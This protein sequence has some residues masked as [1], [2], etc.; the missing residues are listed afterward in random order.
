MPK[1]LVGLNI[2]YKGD[3][4]PTHKDFRQ[5]IEI[6]KDADKYYDQG[7]YFFAIPEFFARR[8]PKRMHCFPYMGA[9]AT[10]TQNVKFGPNVLEVPLF[11]PKHTADV[12]STLDIMSNGRF[13]LGVGVG[14]YEEEYQ[15]FGV[16]WHDRGK[17]L[18]ESLDLMIKFWTEPSVNYKGKFFEIKDDCS[19]PNVQKPHLPIW[20]GGGSEAARRRSAQYG[21]DWAP[22]WWF[23][24]LAEEK[25]V[26]V[27]DKVITAK[28]SVGVETGFT[29]KTALENLKK[30]C[31]KYNRELVLGRPP[32][33]QKEVGFNIS[34][35][36]FNI[37]PDREK[38]LEEAKHFW[39]DVRKARTQG[40]GSIDTKVAYAAIGKPDDVIEK[41]NQAY[42]VGAYCVV[43]YPL[44]TNLKAQW[45]RL[46]ELLPS[47]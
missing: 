19:P 11:H 47:L 31:T 23:V 41:I 9:L 20:V 16:S 39:V 10:V 29:W 7:L 37:N 30:Y 35:F 46:K 2:R 15:N 42:K 4:P 26:Q 34:G 17:I 38:A 33:G 22:S 40:G 12:A 1:K 43:L 8:D 3:V 18:D 14:I 6:A 45:E 44:S 5:L 24:G 36:N 13:I 32:K 27:L 21:N 25:N 28:E